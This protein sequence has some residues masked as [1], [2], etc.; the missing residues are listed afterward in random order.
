[1]NKEIFSK[2]FYLT[3]SL[4]ISAI[5]YNLFIRS[6]GIV[7]GGSGGIAIIFERLLGID[8]S[9][10]IFV[11]SFILAVISMI[12][13]G[14][15]ETVAGFYIAIVYPFLVYATSFLVGVMKLNEEH[16]FV[17]VIFGGILTG[18]ARGINYKT[19]FNTGGI[20]ILSKIVSKKRKVNE[21]YVTF[22]LNFLIVLVGAYYFGYA[23]A[24]YAVIMIYITAIVGNKIFIGVSKN[25]M[26]FIISDKY[27]EINKFILEDLKH[28]IT[29]YDVKGEFSGDK[30]KLLMTVIPTREYFAL[31]SGI[32]EIDEK[33]FVFVSDGYEA[34]KQDVFLNEVLNQTS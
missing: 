3:I 20:G 6:F 25:K 11:V 29:I 18:V 1:M 16:L 22:M 34:G 10:T 28:D 7:A 27:L 14:F 4:L 33:A 12:S 26:F 8:T 19:G 15:K 31:K 30:R 17:A 24:L 23:K 32:K 9:I 13:L 2:Y 5:S 21:S